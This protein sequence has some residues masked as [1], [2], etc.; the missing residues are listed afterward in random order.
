[1]IG[2]KQ[3]DWII[4]NTS[5]RCQQYLKAWECSITKKYIEDNKFQKASELYEQADKVNPEGAKD[6]Y[7]N[8]KDEYINLLMDVASSHLKRQ[9]F[10]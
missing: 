2:R 9:K 3:K 6:E 7:I 10:E 8:F 5:C 4:S 1:M